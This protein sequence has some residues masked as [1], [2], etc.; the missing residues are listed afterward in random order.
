M[1]MTKQIRLWDDNPDKS[2]VSNIVR[3][4]FKQPVTW[5]VFTIEELKQIL[6]LWI[7]GEEIRYPPQKGFKGRWLL[8]EE[9]KKIFQET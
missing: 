5:C 3:I 2:R 4:E 7:Q 8:Y 6:K 1:G 9:I